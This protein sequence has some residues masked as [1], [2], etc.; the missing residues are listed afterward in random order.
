MI[1]GD[2]FKFSHNQVLTGDLST[3]SLFFV[4]FFFLS[5]FLEIQRIIATALNSSLKCLSA[6]GMLSLSFILV[7][8]AQGSDR[9]S[10]SIVKGLCNHFVIC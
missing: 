2:V 3:R 6:M 7:A 9:G 10:V 8:R 5:P 4:F 1:S